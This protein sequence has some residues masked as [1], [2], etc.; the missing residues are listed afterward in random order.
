MDQN[1][2]LFVVASGLLL[3][4]L[5]FFLLRGRFAGPSST[6]E[7]HLNASTIERRRTIA[8]ANFKTFDDPLPEDSHAKIEAGLC[9]DCGA[10]ESLEIVRYSTTDDSIHV[11]CKGC[12]SRL[13]VG[14][15]AGRC[16]MVGRDSTPPQESS[17]A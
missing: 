9:P 12:G 14:I 6:L 2:G 11:K 16:V 13:R 1:W 3:L 7:D 10:D 4:A 17:A 15:F 5:V 8:T